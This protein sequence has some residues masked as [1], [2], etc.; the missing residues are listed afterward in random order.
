MHNII[1]FSPETNG[2]NAIYI[3]SDYK[4]I[5]VDQIT[6]NIIKH[7]IVSSIERLMR[8]KPE[9]RLCNDKLLIVGGSKLGVICHCLKTDTIAWEK[10]GLG[11]QQNNYYY[12]FNRQQH[13]LIKGDR[14]TLIILNLFD[15]SII[16]KVKSVDQIYTHP[17]HDF[18]LRIGKK[19]ALYN[20]DECIDKYEK[21]TPIV[22]DVTSD[23]NGKIFCVSEFG[24]GIK[25]IYSKLHKEIQFRND[26]THQYN[27]VGYNG[28]HF[29]AIG[30]EKSGAIRLY[31]LST[32]G[33]Y[34]YSSNDL[35][36]SNSS[37]ISCVGIRIA[38][39]EKILDAGTF[40]IVFDITAWA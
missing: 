24:S 12:Y 2:N 5:L 17:S 29:V 36:I 21:L 33:E 31:G 9:Y 4:Y 27:A 7:G 8:S 35:P 13:C 22:L 28:K 18:E 6:G 37:E 30:Y 38:D 1:A 40:K 32:D 3:D 26:E 20:G 16:K 25:I 15:G 39:S 23:K 19:Y 11:S 14:K 10:Q 34:L